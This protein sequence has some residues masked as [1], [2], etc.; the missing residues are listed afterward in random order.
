[1]G[2]Q[3]SIIVPI[4]NVEQYLRR[5]IDSILSQSFIEYEVI[6]V[7]DGST[8]NSPDICDEYASMDDRI[9]VIHK[10]NRGLSSA[11]NAG[12]DY[13]L[14][15]RYVS[16]L[17]SDDWIAPQYFQNAIQLCEDYQA[18]IAQFD[19]AYVHSDQERIHQPRIKNKIFEGKELLEYFLIASAKDSIYYSVCTCMFNKDAI[20]NIRFREGKNNEDVDFKYRVL[21]QSNRMVVSNQIMYFYFQSGNTISTGPL[22]KKAIDDAYETAN[23]IEDLT[24]SENYGKIH[25]MSKVKK[26][27][28]PFSLLARYARYGLADGQEKASINLNAL[29]KD[30]RSNYWL[31][32]RAPIPFNR[33][34][35]ASLLCINPKLLRGLFKVINN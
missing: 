34:V 15:G 12:L 32:M 35:L 26:A 10:S 14:K 33:K 28:V 25:F 3:V 13:E 4:Y 16:F 22:R 29:L 11:R 20:G 19:C 1:M 18:D 7:D 23:R 17:D 27:R 6:L 2:V 24:K 5:C 8:D 21:A 9:H 31:L 30:L